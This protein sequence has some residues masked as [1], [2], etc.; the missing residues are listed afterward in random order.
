[1][2]RKLVLWG[3]N[4]QDEKILLG[5]ELIAERK[6]VNIYSLSEAQVTKELNNQLFNEWRNKKEE[7][8]PVETANKEVRELTVS[9]SLLPEG[10]KVDNEE[11][12]GR[13]QT[14]WH[15]VVL[16]N[17]LSETYKQELEDLK[18]RV[19]DLQKFDSGIWEE[20]KGFWSKVQTQIREKNLF[21]EHSDDLKESTNQLFDQLKAL[22]KKLDEEFREK[23]KENK[24]QFFELLEKFDQKIE[25]EI[26]LEGVFNELKD[27]QRKFKNTDFVRRDRSDVW[28]YLDGLFKKVKEKRFGDNAGQKMKS[29][30]ERLEKRYEG[31]LKAIERMQRSISKDEKEYNHQK[32]KQKGF[33]GQLEQQLKEAKLGMIKERMDSKKEKHEDMLK[34][35]Q[36]LEKRMEKQKE[37]ERLQKLKEEAKKEAQKKIEKKVEESE[38]LLKEKKE[39]L[40][41]AAEKLKGKPASNEKDKKVKQ[42]AD[43]SEK[44][45]DFTAADF[46]SK[47]HQLL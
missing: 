18:K 37:K 35:K 31:L 20:L 39:E 7:G 33:A 26:R 1:M 17:K 36:M 13:A 14:E 9:G 25:K 44:T 45:K 15:F 5:M 11:L 23:S 27:V 46:S 8:F 12:V 16:S 28:K 47:I 40:E 10:I 41:R 2:K 6:E 19:D 22:R 21:R 30:L 29:P 42:Y 43:H 34:T 4:S 24:K 3:S 38:R 32:K